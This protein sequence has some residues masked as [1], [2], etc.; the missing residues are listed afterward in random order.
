MYWLRDGN[1]LAFV[2]WLITASVWI[3]GGWLLSTHAFRLKANERLM[4]G[5]GLGLVSYLWFVN[6][7]GRWLSPTMTFIGGAFLVL[8]LGLAF[9]WKGER[10]LLNWKDI[11]LWRWI[12]LAIFLVWMIILVA[13]GMAIFDDRK[14]ISI[15]S[16]MASGDIPPHH[17]MNSAVY[18]AYHYGFQLLGASLMRLGGLLPW[19][20][21]DL[22][23]AIVGA[24][25][26]L[27]AVLLGKRYTDRAWGGIVVAVVFALATGTRYLLLLVPQSLMA[28]IDPKIVVRSV[29]EVVGMPLSQAILQGIVIGDGPPAPFVY[30]YMNGIG[31]PVVMAINAGPSVLSLVILMLIWLLAPRIRRPASF[32]IMTLLFSTWALVWEASYGLILI[33]G[34][35]AILYWFLRERGGV[36]EMFKWIALALLL[37]IP[38]ALLQGGT[39]TEMVRR[40]AGEIGT[41]ATAVPEGAGTFGGFSV[42]WPPVIY[43]G[44]LGAM[45]IFSP[46]KLFVGILE[47]GPVVFF[48]P[49]ITLWSWKRFRQGDWILGIIVLSAWIGFAVPI[50]L[51]YEYNRDI[52]RFSKHGLLIWTVLLVIIIW[53]QS[54]KWAEVFRYLAGIGLALMVFGGIVIASTELSAASK[55]VLSEN[56]INGMDSRVSRD[57]WD[58]LPVGS[59]VFDSRIWRATALTGRLTHV[60]MGKMSYDYG[61][62]PVWEQLRAKPSVEKMLDNGF[63]YVYIDEGWW[64]ELP[65]ESRASLSEVCVRVVTEYQDNER[66]QFRR[67]I[68]LENCKSE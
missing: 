6:L 12:L 50:F 51:T 18:F 21:F 53:D 4:T 24:Y 37:S 13:K 56:V 65:E 29:D 54:F 26:L 10:P 22:S 17:Y 66:N 25:A 62:S 47:L 44:H 49:W 9:A 19:S 58:E 1:P 46:L 41:A 20:A 32:F 3:I 8:A 64:A 61:I 39:I 48:T 52:V 28:K 2:P 42:H 55:T 40:I 33:S 7:L 30:A 35:I 14:N 59:E 57:V 67:L 5:F 38:I 36:D 63:R 27:L 11:T 68:D 31:W 23:K 45:S 60:V 15:I 43:S 16:I 34:L